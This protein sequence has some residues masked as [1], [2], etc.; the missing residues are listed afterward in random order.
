MKQVTVIGAGASGLAAAL[1]AARC[2]ASVVCI[3]KENEPGRKLRL[4]GNGRCNFTNKN[5][6]ADFY[7]SDDPAFVQ[8]VLDCFGTDSC[9]EL[10]ES[11]GIFPVCEKNGC[12]YPASH[13]ASSVVR[14]L[15]TAAKRAGVSFHCGSPAVSLAGYLNKGTCIVACGGFSYPKTGS[16]GSG[17]RLLQQIVDKDDLLPP[18]PALVPL[19]AEDDWIAQTAGVRM[20]AHLCLY[21]EKEKLGEESGQLQ[22]TGTGLSGICAFNLSSKAHPALSRKQKVFCVIDLFPSIEEKTLSEIVFHMLSCAKNTPA[23]DALCGFLPKKL[24]PLLLSF[25]G[26]PKKTPADTLDQNAAAKIA[27]AVKNL[28]VSI[29][30]TGELSSGQVTG[31]GLALRSIDP[32]TMEY[33]KIPG[34][35]V[36][37]ELQNCDGI[38]GGYNLHWAF[39]TGTCAGMAAA[40]AAIG[41]P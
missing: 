41:R 36:T 37:G 25:S 14:G 17:Y 27:S 40:K 15:Y 38:C 32:L 11:A 13:E 34:L 35:Y 9:L 10:M 3:E 39:A 12:Y 26:I 8:R 23:Q 19:L 29:S 16:D 2:G 28:T 7:H 24:L 20:P 18:Y 4:T 21:E 5:L 22:F 33:K 31:G 6:L 1:C 30:G